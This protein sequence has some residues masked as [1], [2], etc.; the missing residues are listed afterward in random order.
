[1]GIEVFLNKGLV[2]RIECKLEAINT[3][4]MVSR[5][6]CDGKLANSLAPTNEAGIEP[7]KRINPVLC[8]IE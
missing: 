5:M 4:P 2:E 6:Y 8:W 3:A 7:T 1:M